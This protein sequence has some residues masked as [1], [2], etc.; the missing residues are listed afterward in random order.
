MKRT[1]LVSLL[2][3]ALL[4][5]AAAPSHAW[6]RGGF[7]HHC[8]FRTSVFV[9]FGPAFWWGPPYWYYPPAYVYYAPPP[10]VVEQPPVYVQQ[11]P[12][13]QLPPASGQE[14]QGYWYYCQSAQA[15]Y[16]NVA[17]CPEA[18]VRVAPR[19]Q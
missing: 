8:C 1:G 10:V 16:P 13:P 12:A 19:P 9:G 14:A 2:V 7:H 18:W 11:Q 5:A 15:Y 4:L 3:L 17:T 6:S